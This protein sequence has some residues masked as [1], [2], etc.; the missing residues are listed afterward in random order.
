ME[1]RKLTLF[2]TPRTRSSGVRTLLEELGADY[3]LEVLNQ[4]KG[5]HLA[6]AFRAVNPMGKVPAL[7]DATGAIVTEQ[8]AIF[9]HLADLFPAAR[10]APSIGDP[11]RGPYLRWLVFYA[12]AFEPALVDRALGRDPGRRAMSPYGEYDTV[13]DTIS[14]ALSGAPYLL[15]EQVS[16]ADILWGTALGWTTA[17]KL[18]PERP[19]I[20]NYVR[21][22][23]SRPAAMRARAK[24]EELA[25]ALQS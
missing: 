25:A 16:A 5:E 4:T 20:M 6:P 15:G 8:V 10:L 24:D 21:R 7:R 11:A 14:G 19:E 1:T 9:I 12:A 23:T 13:I 2:H 18:V 17:F 3:A 22:I